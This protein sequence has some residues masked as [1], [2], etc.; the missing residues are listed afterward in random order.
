MWQQFMRV[1]NSSVLRRFETSAATAFESQVDPIILAKQVL[2]LEQN[3][4]L[5]QSKINETSMD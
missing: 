4:E 5:I 1:P 2:L 3:E